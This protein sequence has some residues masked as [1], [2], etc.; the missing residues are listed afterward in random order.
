MPPATT[1]AVTPSTSVLGAEVTGID[2]AGALSERDLQ[3]IRDAVLRHAVVVVRDQ[4]LSADDQ[5]AFMDRLYGRRVPHMSSPPFSLPGRPE[6]LIVSNIV[7]NGHP[8][9]ISDAGLL[10]HTDTCF[11]ANPELFVSLYALEIPFHDGVALGDTRWT[12]TI[13][14]YDALPESIK[15]ELAGRKVCQ[16]FPFHIEK[17]RSIGALTRP[18]DVQKSFP[19]P[20]LFPAVRTH[21]ITGRKLLY[22]NESFSAYIEGLTPE[23]SHMLLEELWAHLAQPRFVYQHSWRKNDFVIF[24]NC[25]TQHLATFDYGTLPRRLHRCGTDGPTPE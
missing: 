12:S 5:A 18:S 4:H 15:A 8:I 21:P 13:S 14:A 6:I 17:M 10:W 25:A 7:E 1:I 9:G 2:I 20:Q 22:V 23:R 19:A 11:T 3:T 24:D 16:S